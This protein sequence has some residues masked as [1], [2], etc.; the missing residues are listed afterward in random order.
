MTKKIGI[1][2]INLGTPDSA[3]VKDVRKYLKEFLSDP[4]VI[5]L[6]PIA[7]WIL[8]NLFILPTRPKKSAEAYEKIWTNSGSPLLVHGEKLMQGLQDEL[9]EHITVTLGMR[10]GSPSIASAA[11]KLKLAHCDEIIILPLFPQYSSAATGSAIETVL[12]IYAGENTIP[13]IHLISEFYQEPCFVDASVVVIE[14]SLRNFQT[15]HILFSYHG[16]PERHIIKSGCSTNHCDMHQHCPAITEKNR[17]CYRAQCFASTELL[18]KKLDLKESQ[19]S[20]SFQSRL[21]RTPWI[22]PYTDEVLPELAKKGIK[23]LA[24]AC[25]SF[26]ADCLETIEEIGMQARDQWLSLGGKEFLQIPCLNA[27]TVWIKGLAEFLKK[28]FENTK[29]GKL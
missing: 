10:Y 5:D 1:L 6:P 22:K 24:I 25:P 27:E 21:G 23:N 20:T 18:A 12:K 19:Y 13:G 17:Y 16:L 9:G 4:R 26:V 3:N 29:T 11:A 2:L 15:D 8:V 14:N 7:R 28:T